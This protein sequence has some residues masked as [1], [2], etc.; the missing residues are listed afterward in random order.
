MSG[1]GKN[2]TKTKMFEKFIHLWKAGP[3]MM[4][5]VPDKN[6]LYYVSEGTVMFFLHKDAFDSLMIMMKDENIPCSENAYTCRFGKEILDQ[7]NTDSPCQVYAGAS[8]NGLWKYAEAENGKFT[9][10]T[11]QR[12]CYINPKSVYIVP[13]VYNNVEYGA[14]YSVFD[15][16]YTYVLPCRVPE[17][18]KDE[19]KANTE[20]YLAEK[21]EKA[22]KRKNQTA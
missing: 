19:I 16:F 1:K 9:F 4:S 2:M 3:Y 6:D 22:R 20:K 11:K 15:D 5:S 21:A 13:Y 12:E 8:N 17:N 7:I 10:F 18:I 14:L